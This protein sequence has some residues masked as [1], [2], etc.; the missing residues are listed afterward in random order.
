MIYLSIFQLLFLLFLGQADMKSSKA[1][2]VGPE[3]EEL[4]LSVDEKA[5][6][7]G[8]NDYR[9]QK[10]L[11]AIPLS[12]ALTKVAKSH[13]WDLNENYDLSQRAKCNPH[14]WSQQDDW[15]G[16]C[17]T[18]NHKDPNCMWDKPKEI[19]GYPAAGYEIV[20]WNSSEAK[21]SA[22][23]EGWK[24]SHGHNQV[25]INLEIWK[26]VEWKALGIA[27]KDNYA[28]AW[29]GDTVDERGA[30]NLCNNEGL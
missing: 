11:P 3:E 9:K 24:K 28:I 29:F 26:K 5:L 21:P 25:M 15:T 30:A 14:S 8:I 27:I 7:E 12:A 22:A 19:A 20:Y 6:F 10:K 13:A 1:Q 16:C 2:N 17:Y 23:L 4:C 18:D